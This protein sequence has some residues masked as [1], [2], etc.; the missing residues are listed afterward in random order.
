MAFVSTCTGIEGCPC[1]ACGWDAMAEQVAENWNPPPPPVLRRNEP[2]PFIYDPLPMQ[3]EEP[4]IYSYNIPRT[5]SISERSIAISLP[6]VEGEIFI[7]EDIFFASEPAPTI[8]ICLWLRPC[9]RK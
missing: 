5:Y 9:F 6:N 8:I 7:L 2:P 1:G 4:Q 3:I